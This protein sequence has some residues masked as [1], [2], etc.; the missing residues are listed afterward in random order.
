MN[1]IRYQFDAVSY[2]GGGVT[3]NPIVTGMAAFMAA[4]GLTN[5]SSGNSQA[6]STHGGN[7]IATKLF[8]KGALVAWSLAPNTVVLQLFV[9]GEYSDVDVEAAM[10]ALTQATSANIVVD[11]TRVG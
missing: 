7:F 1:A 4:L 8:Q 5:P 2:P 9:V 3:T 11:R 10:L 6:V